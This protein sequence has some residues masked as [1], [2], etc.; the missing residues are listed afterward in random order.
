MG[1]NFFDEFPFERWIFISS[2]S[3]SCSVKLLKI[4][5]VWAVGESVNSRRSS[6]LFFCVFWAINEEMG[7]IWPI[8]HYFNR[9]VLVVFLKVAG[10]HLL[11]CCC[12]RVKSHL[13][14]V[15][16][17]PQAFQREFSHIS[18]RRL[19]SECSLNPCPAGPF[20][21]GLKR[22]EALGSV[23]HF[24]LPFRLSC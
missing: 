4:Q 9:E 13:E 19:H 23:A 15:S 21:Q 14:A 6:E 17:F 8:V 2:A 5:I 18:I 1:S 3:Y 12:F 11:S 16:G 10:A 7:S 22:L 20:N 24:L